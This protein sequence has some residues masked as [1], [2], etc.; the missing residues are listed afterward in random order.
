[1]DG[2]YIKTASGEKVVFTAV[3]HE[4]NCIN[5]LTAKKQS[6]NPHAM[7]TTRRNE[8]QPANG[9]PARVSHLFLDACDTIEILFRL[10]QSH[11]HPKRKKFRWKQPP[12]PGNGAEQIYQQAGNPKIKRV[13]NRALRKLLYIFRTLQSGTVLTS[14]P[15]QA[16]ITAKICIEIMEKPNIKLHCIKYFSRKYN[17]SPSTLQRIFKAQLRTSL[18]QY[19]TVECMK[20]AVRLRNDNWMN[21]DDIA[22]ELGYAD[23][24][25]FSKIFHRFLA[26]YTS[27]FD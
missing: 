5:L 27:D 9:A 23:R 10:Y 12:R 20:K 14:M 17:I 25:G 7:H 3:R 18:H 1:M 16:A 2:I 24:S 8:S 6:C 13:Y 22:E 26:T 11:M 19:V 15:T 4:P 21:M